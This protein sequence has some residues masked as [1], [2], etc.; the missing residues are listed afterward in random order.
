MLNRVIGIE[1]DIYYPEPTERRGR[2]RRLP[3]GIVCV[4]IAILALGW[5]VND[6][7]PRRAVAVAGASYLAHGSN[8]PA[9]TASPATPAAAAAADW[10]IA[11][12][13][14]PQG[15]PIDPT[16]SDWLITQNWQQHRINEG[17]NVGALDFAFINNINAVG[18]PIHAT[19]RGIVGTMK[20]RADGSGYGNAV[21]ILGFI[22]PQ[23]GVS[24]NTVYGHFSKVDVVDGQT[25]NRGDHLGEMGSTGFSTGPHVHYEVW[26][27]HTDIAAIPPDRVHHG[28]QGCQNI[29]PMPF[30]QELRKE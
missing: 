11:A 17:V 3:V 8:A 16:R 27:C 13:D 19:E 15:R 6:F 7:V 2:G 24:N 1:R 30:I 21:Y 18:S 29:D 5:L 12:G 22:N 25:V 20:D 28:S 4:V 14:V 26:Q 10:S 9:V 23:T